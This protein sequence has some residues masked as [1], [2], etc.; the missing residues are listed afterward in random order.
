[1]AYPLLSTE[2]DTNTIIFEYTL[3]TDT[4]KHNHFR[5]YTLDGHIH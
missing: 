1:M 5:V 2:V 4:Y 3:R